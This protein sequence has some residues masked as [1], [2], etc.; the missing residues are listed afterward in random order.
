MATFTLSNRFILQATNENKNTW[1]GFLNNGA[2]SLIDSAMDGITSLAMSGDVVLTTASGASDQ[3]RRR[4]LN[5]TSTGGANRTITLPALEKWYIVRNAGAQQVTLKT[6]A[7]AG[8]IVPAGSNATIMCD[9]L[10]CHKI[11]NSGW[12][13][14]ASANFTGGAVTQEITLT[15]FGR[16]EFMLAIAG[17]SLTNTGNIH[18]SFS[19]D[20]SNW[21]NTVNIWT[22]SG[23]AATIYGGIHIPDPTADEGLVIVGVEELSANRTIDSDQCQTGGS[24][25]RTPTG[26]ATIAWRLSGGI[27]YIRIIAVGGATFDAGSYKVRGR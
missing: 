2:L 10:D 24:T 25:G 20:G 5:I 4:I 17:L 27:K 26:A 22:A 19:D 12:A 18:V 15:G 21:S 14:V 11:G 7:G 3:A 6:A 8:I 1:G 23:A 13:T 9:A 16:Q